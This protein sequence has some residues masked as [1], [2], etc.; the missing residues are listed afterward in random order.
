MGELAFSA[1]AG[2]MG[3][4]MSGAGEAPEPAL[5][6]STRPAV[7]ARTGVQLGAAFVSPLGPHGSHKGG[8]WH[9]SDLQTEG[10]L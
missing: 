9:L 5:D 7:G 3:P 8:H 4:A 10:E 2:V 6:V 1:A